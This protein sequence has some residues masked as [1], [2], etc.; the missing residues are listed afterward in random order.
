[1]VSAA[2]TLFGRRA[3]VR[4]GSRQLQLTRRYER[5]GKAF[6]PLYCLAISAK[7][8][9]L[10]NIVDNQTVIRKISA[11]GL[12]GLRQLKNYEPTKSKLT[13]PDHVAAPLDK[14]T[15]KRNYGDLAHGST[16]RL[17]CDIWRI[18]IDCFRTGRQSEIDAIIDKLP[19]LQ[20]PQYSQITLSGTHLFD[21]Y[22]NLPNMRGFQFFASFPAP[23]CPPGL[24]SKYIDAPYDGHKALCNTTLYA[25]VPENGVT[26]ELI[27]EWKVS[28][29][30]LFRRDTNE[31][32]HGLFDPK[33]RLSLCTM[34]QYLKGYFDHGEL[35]SEGLFGELSRKT[36][37][38]LDKHYIG[39]ETTPLDD[40][41]ELIDD[42]EE[43]VLEC[44]DLILRDVNRNLQPLIDAG[45][46]FRQVKRL[47]FAEMDAIKSNVE[48]REDGTLSGR[49]QEDD[50]LDAND[51]AWPERLK[52]WHMLRSFGRF[53][54]IAKLSGQSIED[55]NKAARFGDNEGSSDY[56]KYV[57]PKDFDWAAV[58]DAID[59][60]SGR[61]DRQAALKTVK[62]Q[63]RKSKTIRKTRMVLAE[64]FKFGYEVF[65]D[66][67]IEHPCVSNGATRKIR[68]RRKAGIP[69]RYT[70]ETQFKNC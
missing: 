24:N 54:E 33:W 36:V 30:G 66:A 8:Y 50:D 46:E 59:T 11:H 64:I 56:L 28:R 47:T 39:K 25:S 68:Q 10:F 31:F 35:K 65:E 12:G 1:M 19:Q 7:R 5:T 27:E 41:S 9:A 40:D 18:A 29:T 16:A 34:A 13:K 14:E 48:I 69:A 15:E 23:R 43:P 57:P 37:I 2:F 70:P 20:V 44:N 21:L 51:V 38:S 17:L 22:P 60:R 6:E 62:A 26:R 61:R 3:A 49:T 63:V 55:L 52:T 4:V 53:A 42:G 67:A 58:R 45:I 32:P